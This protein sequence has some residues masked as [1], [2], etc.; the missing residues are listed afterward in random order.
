MPK[1]EFLEIEIVNIFAA[2]F[3]VKEAPLHTLSYLQVGQAVL[4]L[5]SA[6]LP[7]QLFLHLGFDVDKQLL[8]NVPRLI[9]VVW[10]QTAAVNHAIEGSFPHAVS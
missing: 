3:K 6:P 8:L 7:S 2:F 1:K 9:T 10:G 4:L 5:I